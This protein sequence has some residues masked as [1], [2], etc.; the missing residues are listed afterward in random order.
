MKYNFMKKKSRFLAYKP[1]VFKNTK[2]KIQME[3]GNWRINFY[4]EKKCYKTDDIHFIMSM[5]IIIMR[6]I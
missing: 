6:I 2:K 3:M 4:Y 1:L 5:T